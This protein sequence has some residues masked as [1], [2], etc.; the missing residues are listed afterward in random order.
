M[1]YGESKG[2]ASAER[3]TT[4]L[5]LDYKFTERFSFFGKAEGLEDRFSGIDLRYHLGGGIGYQVLRGPIHLLITETGMNYTREE[6]TDNTELTYRAG[7]FFVRYDYLFTEKNKFF[8]SVE[9]LYDFEDSENYNVNSETAII[10]A[11][12]NF[13]P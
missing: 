6:H 2:T 11:L 1:L 3:Y 5:R 10:S 7:R 4:A 8:Q 13:F 12:N 9:Y